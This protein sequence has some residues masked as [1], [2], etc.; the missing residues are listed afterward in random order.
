MKKTFAK[1][2]AVAATN[3][4]WLSLQGLNFYYEGGLL[5]RLQKGY[6]S[7]VFRSKG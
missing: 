6:P 1:R 2:H 4:T 7:S 5:G 3:S